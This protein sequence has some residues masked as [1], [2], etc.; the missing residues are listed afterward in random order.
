MENKEIGFNESI[1]LI[2]GKTCKVHNIIYGENKP[3]KRILRVFPYAKAF[4]TSNKPVRV[5]KEFINP[6][7]DLIPSHLQDNKIV[8][9]V[10]D[11]NS[12]GASSRFAVWFQN[13]WAMIS[14]VEDIRIN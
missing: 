12:L 14:R 9:I 4:L 8:V 10:Q 2:E 13:S 3:E 5:S 11:D 7:W 6:I 1:D